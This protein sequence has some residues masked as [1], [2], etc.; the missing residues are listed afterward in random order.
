LET[1]RLAAAH[2][3]PMSRRPI[4]IPPGR[5]MKRPPPIR[6][7]GAIRRNHFANNRVGAAPSS[8]GLCMPVHVLPIFC[9]AAAPRATSN[10]DS[11]K[12]PADAIS[13]RRRDSEFPLPFGSGGQRTAH[14][15][16]IRPEGLPAYVSRETLV[17]PEG[18]AARAFPCIDSSASRGRDSSHSSAACQARRN[19]TACCS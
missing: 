9:P 10:A 4:A 14:R 11:K 1:R 13:I 15:G 12:K 19:A 17:S 7:A 3:H 18:L 8:S 6:A 2:F 16:V 5:K